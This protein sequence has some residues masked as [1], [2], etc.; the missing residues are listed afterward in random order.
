MKKIASFPSS[1]YTPENYRPQGS[2][3]YL[4]LRNK[5]SY[6]RLGDLKLADLGITAAQMSVLLLISH[7][8][9]A[10]ISSLSQSLG[11]NA[12]ATVRV[13]QKLEKM[14]LIQKAPSKK[15]GRVIGL[16]LTTAGK[17]TAISIPPL[18]CDLLNQSLAGFTEKE[19][20][21]LRNFLL[22]IEK[23]NLQQ[24]EVAL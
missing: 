19:F 22:R 17:K 1:F 5:S 12:A 15:D 16:S 7:T 24:L 21:Q 18:W 23:N 6:Q 10:T 4:M 3:A 8:E 9:A 11:V 20:E 14:K 2:V 13:V